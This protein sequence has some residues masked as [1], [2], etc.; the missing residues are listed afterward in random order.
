MR[1]FATPLFV[2]ALLF[3]ATGC[4]GQLE[5]GQDVEVAD[6]H[7]DSIQG[8]LGE[9]AFDG[10]P[11]IREMR[12]DRGSLHLD[13]RLADREQNWAV[14]VALTIPRSR[15][16]DGIEGSRL[17]LRTD[18]AEMVGCSGPED[19]DWDYDCQPDDLNVEVVEDKDSLMVDF[20]GT[21]TGDGCTVPYGMPPEPQDVG[22]SVEL[23]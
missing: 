22:G 1:V 8:A 9:V 12:L 20:D 5:T 3:A 19:G 11:E 14:M 23:F 2:A 17:A 7:V 10:Q 18:E 16:T 4:V 21:F 13:L 15:V 6:V